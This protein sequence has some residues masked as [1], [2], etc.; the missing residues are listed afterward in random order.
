MQI[1]W[2]E[3]SMLI[4]GKF[5]KPYS[6]QLNT[7]YTTTDLT[8]HFDTL[9]L[10]HTLLLGGDYYKTDNYGIFYNGTPLPAIDVYN[11]VHTGSIT[12][13]SS[14]PFSNSTDFYGIYAQDQIKLPHNIHVMGG[15]RYQGIDQKDKLAHITTPNVHAVTP[16]VG[17]LWQPQKWLSLYGN[18]VENFG[19]TNGQ[20]A[21]G[22]ML[23]PES[24]QQWEGGLKTEFFDGRLSSTLSY[25]DL[26]KQN[27]ATT[28]LT[29]P[30]YS[31]A[32]GEVRSRGPEVDIKGEILPGWNA[33]ATY[34]NLDVRVTK[35]N[36]GLEGNRMYGVP[37]NMGSLWN[38]YDF[39]QATLKGLKVGGGLTLRDS[40]TNPSNTYNVPSYTTVD[41]MAAYSLKLNKSKISFQLNVNN[42]LDKNYFQAMTSDLNASSRVTIGTPRS[43]MGSVKIEF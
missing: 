3:N 36:S 1:S 26:T 28:D 30:L 14:N 27:V 34:A 42:L 2:L 31:I 15:L 38:T 22:S 41:L 32:I 17:I 37:R 19:A 12:P 25:F 9:G 40:S 10:K 43:L 20:K 4:S 6:T 23:P 7:F 21:D 18:Y 39:Q 8:G 5:W 11:P 13:T 24:A 29:N 16:R 33:I 35:D